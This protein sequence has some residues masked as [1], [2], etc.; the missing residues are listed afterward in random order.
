MQAVRHGFFKFTAIML[1]VL[2]LV[3]IG[4]LTAYAGGGSGGGKDGGASAPA[5]E[6]DPTPEP[7]PEPDPSPDP[8]PE[9]DA[10]GGNDGNNH[11]HDDGANDAP[12]RD[13]PVTDTPARDIPAENAPTENAPARDAPIRGGVAAAP[14]QIQ[15]TVGALTYSRDGNVGRMDVPPIVYSG[16]TMV[17]LRFFSN[18]FGAQID[19]D[20]N[21]RAVT[22]N[23]QGEVLSFIVGDSVPGMDVPAMITDGRTLVPLR[24]ISEFFGANV[25][26]AAETQTI[27]V[28][29]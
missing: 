27:T 2:M 14:M 1:V 13:V 15:L 7:D 28:T 10:P 25:E 4:G 5:P 29:M 8:D 11:H 12:V 17:P 18:V 21:T 19:W 20:A 23:H 22:I 24:F 16:R 9:P 6:P 26:W 3:S